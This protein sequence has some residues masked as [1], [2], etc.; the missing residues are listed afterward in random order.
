MLLSSDYLSDAHLLEEL[1][2]IHS[3]TVQECQ[4]SK[5]IVKLISSAGVFTGL[6]VYTDPELLRK[7]V[8]SLLFL[9]YHT[10]PK[11]RKVT[12]EKLYTAILTMEDYSPIIPGGED[13][14]D[15]IIETLSETNWD[16]TVLKE[17]V[18]GKERVYS[19]FGMAPA[20]PAA[21][22]GAGASGDGSMMI[23]T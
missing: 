22:G 10:F 20:K 1:H 14:Y 4:K 19:Y 2:Q 6:L 9:L 17:L 21:T 16:G 8:K 23:I 3:I 15:Q 11:V 18:P 7:A 12:A 5:N 13:H